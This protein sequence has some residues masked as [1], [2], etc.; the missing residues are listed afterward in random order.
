MELFKHLAFPEVV[1]TR[2][3]EYSRCVA[4]LSSTPPFWAVGH[5]GFSTASNYPFQ[6]GRRR[7]KKIMTGAQERV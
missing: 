6:P 4:S 2:P 5:Y 3:F 7:A 1:K